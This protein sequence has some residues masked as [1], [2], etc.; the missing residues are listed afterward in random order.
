MNKME[1]RDLSKY[2]KLAQVEELNFCHAERHSAAVYLKALWLNDTQR[3]NEYESLGDTPR[4][5]LMNK[6]EYDKGLLFGFTEKKFNEY[7]WLSNAKFTEQERIEFFHKKGWVAHNYLILGKG[8]NGK[9]TYG[10]SYSTGGAGGGYGISVWGKI[11]DSRKACLA[12][13]L[14]E[15]MDGHR[16]NGISLKNDTSNFNPQYSRIIVKQVKD[17]YDTITGRKVIQLSLF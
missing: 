16:K 1:Y 13:A 15:I 14:Q 4:Q 9:W 17:L 11:F 5:F 12:A 3:L 10:A 7:G 2:E 6:R 8:L